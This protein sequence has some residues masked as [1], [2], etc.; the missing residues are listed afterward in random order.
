MIAGRE[1]TAARFAGHAAP[2]CGG[3]GDR[4]NRWRTTRTSWCA[5]LLGKSSGVHAP[6]RR[7]RASAVRAA[8]P[9]FSS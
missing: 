2:L 4:V 8:H 6:G 7:D 9:D 5:G 1:T 3:P